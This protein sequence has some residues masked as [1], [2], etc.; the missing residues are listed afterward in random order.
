MSKSVGVLQRKLIALNAYT[1][2]RERLEI[3]ELRY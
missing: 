2:K 1:T 3:N